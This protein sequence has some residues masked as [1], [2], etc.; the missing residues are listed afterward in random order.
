MLV[1]DSVLQGSVKM[2]S[3][4]ESKLSERSLVKSYL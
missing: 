3:S 4:K 2:S 1:T